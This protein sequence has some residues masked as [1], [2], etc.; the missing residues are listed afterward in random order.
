MYWAVLSGS[1]LSVP[2]SAFTTW[3]V[4]TP[5]PLQAALEMF[6]HISSCGTLLVL[7]LV[8]CICESSLPALVCFHHT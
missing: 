1:P 6:E 2:V 8:S 3:E 5:S 7:D 4:G